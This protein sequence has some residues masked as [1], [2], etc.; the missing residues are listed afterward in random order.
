[1]PDDF[2]P[3]PLR[4]SYGVRRYAFGDRAIPERLGKADAPEGI[5]AETWEVSDHDDEPATILDGAYR[6]TPLRELVAQYPHELVRPGFRGERLPLLVKFLD[7]HHMLPV[8]VH[9]DDERAAARYGEP[10]GKDEAWHVLWAADDAS[11]LAGVRPDVSRAALRA[12]LQARAYD[13]VMLR[14]DVRS[15]DTVD[16]PGGV[17]HSFGPGLVILEVQQT[18]D[19]AESAM[20]TD[21]YGAE[22][23]Q[24]RWEANIEATLE[25][26]TSDARPRPLP[27]QLLY[28]DAT[29]TRMLGCRNERFVL[30][31][32]TL[33]GSVAARPG[34]GGFVA[35]T[36]L[37]AALT[38]DYDGGSE[39]VERAASRLLPA[40]LGEV[41]VRP[42]EETEIVLCF[43]PNPGTDGS[44]DP[45]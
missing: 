33:R 45:G 25:L 6:G 31:R 7:A 26:L 39:R 35:L 42:E 1:M 38:I 21:L 41:N 16:V 23:P 11:V 28:E 44:A 22:L 8:H 27:L 17:L 2:T 30:E 36:N 10:N 18:S 14:H 19:L 24:A 29:L 5:V 37:G 12:A 32:W 4:L 13:D 40:A 3:Y 20:P 15:G 34:E 43:E 9:P